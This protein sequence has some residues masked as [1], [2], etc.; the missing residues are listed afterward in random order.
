MGRCFFNGRE[1]LVRNTIFNKNFP[2]SFYDK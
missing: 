1:D 2:L